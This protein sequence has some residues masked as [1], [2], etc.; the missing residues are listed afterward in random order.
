MICHTALAM[1]S[2]E[3]DIKIEVALVIFSDT[4]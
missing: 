3:L 2:L 1:D 4:L